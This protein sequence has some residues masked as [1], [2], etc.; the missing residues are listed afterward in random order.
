MFCCHSDFSCCE[1]ACH[2]LR[3]GGVVCDGFHVLKCNAACGVVVCD[4]VK[5][6][7][8]IVQSETL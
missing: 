6:S 7:V 5:C 8:V 1:A 3:C 4:V 2:D